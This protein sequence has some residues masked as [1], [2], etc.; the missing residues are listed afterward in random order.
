MLVAIH[1]VF[2]QSH[3]CGIRSMGWFLELSELDCFI[4]SS[5]G[6][7]QKFA[8]QVEHLIGQF[9][10]QED[11]RLGQLMPKR[12]ITLCEDETFHPQICL[13]AIEPVS[14]FLILEAYA[15]KR[16][17][18]TWNAFV[19]AAIKP[20]SVDVI[21]CVSDQ[22][23]ALIS[24]AESHL[25][26]HHSPDVFHV[27]YEL[28]KA[29]SLA[30]NRQVEK[31][32]VDH[33]VAITA[34][35]ESLDKSRAFDKTYP[36]TIR[37]LE[38]EKALNQNALELQKVC[39]ETRERFEATTD[40]KQRA[41]KARCGIANDY[42]PFE[43]KTGKPMES[44]DVQNRLNE[45]FKTLHSIA[46]DA[47]L[48]QGAHDRIAKAQRV[49]P[50]MIATIVFFWCTIKLFG[51]RLGCSEEVTRI[52]RDEL[53]AGYYIARVAQR[54][55]KADEAKRLKELS[56]LILA[57]ARSPDRSFGQLPESL[58]LTLEQQAQQAAD[59]FQRSSSCVEGRNG[60]L[61]L[62][63]HGLRELTPSKL[64]ALRT[65]HNYLIE[66][67]DGTTA[68]ERLFGIKPRVLFGWLLEQLPMPSRPRKRRK[69]P[70]LI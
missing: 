53:V 68:A 64:K 41:R 7:Q 44:G 2:G 49:L 69:Q 50:S 19:D 20:F 57:R 62:R 10:E 13:V 63:H 27:Q 38:C 42:H 65:I 22:A 37:E 8:S 3:D 11:Q 39:Q 17:A 70:G 24:H 45:H 40:R 4:A 35:L 66:R 23:L 34:H 55:Q 51:E 28:S 36:C 25:G 12:S 15:D 18:V 32:K 67:E 46:E 33:E 14:N 43:L 9:G 58:R 48:S 26:V 31:A 6:A 59:V 16:D 56:D 47:K 61:S 60:Q 54:Q 5:Y 30:L 1:L 52:W 21:Q 29:T